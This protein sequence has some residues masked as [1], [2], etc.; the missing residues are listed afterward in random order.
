MA[1]L[2]MGDFF[3]LNKLYTHPSASS[4]STLRQGPPFDE[5]VGVNVSLKIGLYIKV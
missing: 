1:L 3:V 2:V 5:G 4:A